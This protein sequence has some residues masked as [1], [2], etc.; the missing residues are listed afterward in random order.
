MREDEHHIYLTQDT[1]WGRERLELFDK[2]KA[3]Y[4][5]AIDEQIESIGDDDDQLSFRLQLLFSQ[6]S[7][8]MGQASSTVQI[9]RNIDNQIL[10]KIH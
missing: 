9:A 2:F 5:E 8:A 3:S 6:Y 10:G 1:D 7:T 4:D